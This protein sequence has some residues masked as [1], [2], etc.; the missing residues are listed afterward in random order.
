MPSFLKASLVL[1]EWR[2]YRQFEHATA[3]PEHAQAHVLRT[4][5]TENTDTSF[6]QEHGFSAITTPSEYRRRVPVRDYEGFRPYI[7]RVSARQ[8]KVLTT[9]TPFMF[10]TTSGTTGEP[11]YIPVS[12]SWHEQLAAQMRLWTFYTLRDHPQCFDQKIVTIVSPAVESHTS[13]A[14]PVGAMSGVTYQR[15]PWLIRRQ[16]AVPYEVTLIGDYETRYFLTMR[17]ALAQ[18]ISVLATPNPTTLLRLAEVATIHAEAMVR[19]IHDG[20]LGVPDPVVIPA[21]QPFHADVLHQL[22]AS[23]APDPERARFLARIMQKFGTLSLHQCWPE[24]KLIACWLGGTAGIHAKHLADYYGPDVTLRDLGLLAS[25][26]RMTI[27]IEDH[28][29]AGVLAVQ[30]NFYEFI[31]EEEID[32]PHPSILLAHEIEYGKRYFI[33][34]SGRNG[35]YRYDINDVVEVQGFYHRTPKVA[36][37]RKGR[38]MVNI[39][40]EKLHLSHIQAAIHEAER[41]SYLP[42]WQFR[43]IP[44]VE[45]RCYDVLVEFQDALSPEVQPSVFLQVFDQTLARLNNEY[46]AKRAS[47][48]LSPPQL[49]VMQRGWSERCCQQEFHS[50]KRESQYKWSVI[51]PQWDDISRA[52]VFRKLDAPKEGGQPSVIS[53]QLQGIGDLHK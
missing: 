44:D 13:T 25:E 12:P 2:H 14:I 27:P 32:A 11:K 10:T 26:G 36:F 16:Y 17:F 40:G 6:G 45:G 50:G 28:T 18:A 3:H 37:V 31:P 35:L 23:L 4:M 1:R 34:L 24:L 52:E 38:D 53:G 8:E 22:K 48:R 33:I 19:A 21:A 29:P 15:I 7:N 20:V 30:D 9:E 51:Q 39:T 49:H 46:A 41:H 42:V 43:L 5:L 47:Q